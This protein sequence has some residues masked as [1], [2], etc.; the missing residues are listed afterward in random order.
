MQTLERYDWAGNIREL[1]NVLQRAIILSPGSTL[2]LGDAWMP[3]LQPRQAA[4]LVTLADVERRHIQGSR[5]G[6]L[7]DRGAVAPRSRQ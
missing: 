1:E 4:E 3:A 7:A 6:P 2:T 5:N